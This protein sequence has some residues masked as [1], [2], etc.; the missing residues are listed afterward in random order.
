MCKKTLKKIVILTIFYLVT[1][2]CAP[3]DKCTPI[4]TGDYD[5][6]IRVA[7]IGDS[8]TYG[9]MVENRGQNSYPAQLA[10]M[11]GDKWDVRNFGVSGAT[12]LKAG[13]K[14]YWQQKA[15]AEALVFEPDVVIIKLGTNDTKPVNWKYGHRFTADY[16]EMIDIFASLPTQPKIWI[17]YP[18]YIRP[19]H[20][21]IRGSV[22]VNEQIP[23]IKRIADEK[24]AS[25]I[26]LHT[27][28]LGKP[29]M[30]ADKVHPNATGAKILAGTVYQALTCKKVITE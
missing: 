14:P 26:D 20:R 17:C 19:G 2:G 25:I 15:F 1:V 11:L 8:I 12:M 30:Y 5:S 6:L 13:D 28:L 10:R 4:R 9:L 18:A 3:S 16:K 7:C 29:E 24:G 22:A 21:A 27:P 23:A